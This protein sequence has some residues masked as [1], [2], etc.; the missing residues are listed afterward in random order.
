MQEPNVIRQALDAYI[1]QGETGQLVRQYRLAFPHT[2]RVID[3]SCSRCMNELYSKLLYLYETKYTDMAKTNTP[4]TDESKEA[5]G[6]ELKL[7]AKFRGSTIVLARAGKRI[8]ADTATQ[9]QLQWLK[10][11]GY[12]HYLA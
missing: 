9:E 7:Q 12:E 3:E 2:G 1:Q 10:D 8:E 4:D 5:K 11:N 6:K